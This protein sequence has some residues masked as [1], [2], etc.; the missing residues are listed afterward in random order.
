MPFVNG[1]LV[2]GVFTEDEKRRMAAALT[3][4]MVQSDGPSRLTPPGTP[5]SP[6][7]THGSRTSARTSRRSPSRP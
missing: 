7:S 3:D 5:R 2:D 4:V 6:S 1:K